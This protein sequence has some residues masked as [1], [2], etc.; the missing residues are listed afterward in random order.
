MV[1]FSFY[2]I[3]FAIAPTTLANCP[4]FPL[5]KLFEKDESVFYSDVCG[6]IGHLLDNFGT[7]YL[8][9]PN[10]F[11]LKRFEPEA[12]LRKSTLINIRPS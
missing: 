10:M 12:I 7:I 1:D 5:F 3:S 6:I 8:V 9:T 11:Y 2:A 4:H